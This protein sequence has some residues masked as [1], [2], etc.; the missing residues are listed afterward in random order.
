MTS[1]NLTDDEWQRLFRFKGYGN[2]AGRFW[3]IGIEERGVGDIEELRARLN[4]RELEDLLESQ[5]SMEI[6][7][8]NTLNPDKLIPTWSTMMRIVLRLESDPN[9]K[10]PERIR[11]YQ[12]D[13][14]GKLTGDIFLTELLPLPK[15]SDLAWPAFWPFANWDHYAEKVMPIRIRIL[16]D[17]LEA[18]NPQY[19]FCYGKGYW[20][21]F[22]KLFPG[23]DFSRS[24]DNRF[25]IGHT[26]ITTV[27]LTPFFSWRAGMTT[28]RVDSLVASLLSS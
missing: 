6:W 4:Y 11:R 23:M 24:P 19:V 27:V 15:E 25:E 17:L 2:P 5:T 14:L 21:H 9:W 12:R 28:S 16:T 18:N 3:F 7:G 13:H 1:G 20:P 8:S 10:D 22:K 26:E